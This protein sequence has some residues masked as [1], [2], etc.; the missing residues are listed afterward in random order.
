MIRSMS[1]IGEHGEIIE[2]A[3]SGGPIAISDAELRERCRTAP[4]FIRRRMDARREA[5]GLP[6]LWG[7]RAH[8]RRAAATGLV[9]RM[10]AFLATTRARLSR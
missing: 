7:S 9:S 3:G 2:H 1:H 10:R 6:P 5:R 4:L 8:G